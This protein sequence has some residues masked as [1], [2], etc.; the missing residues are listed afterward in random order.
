MG[1]WIFEDGDWSSD[2][3]PE[4][5]RAEQDQ[6]EWKQRR[7]LEDEWLKRQPGL[8]IVPVRQEKEQERIPPL[9]PDQIQH[10]IDSLD[11]PPSPPFET[12]Y[13]N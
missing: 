6:R 10:I 4:I 2:D 12:P 3:K 13:L 7:Q 9:S 8:Q 5:D 11:T 1:T